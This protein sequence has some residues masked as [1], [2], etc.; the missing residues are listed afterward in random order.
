[1]RPTPAAIGGNVRT[2][3]TKRARITASGPKRWKKAFVRSTFALEN[4]PLS[5]RSK[6]GGPAF[7]PMK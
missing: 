3:G 4:S 5:L 2:T 1:M 6:I 7:L